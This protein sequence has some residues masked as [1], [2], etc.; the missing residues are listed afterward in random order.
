MIHVH[1]QRLELRPME[2]AD[3]DRVVEILGDEMVKKT[4]MVPDITS[5]EM[6]DKLFQRLKECCT[7]EGR[8]GAGAYFQG[9]L[10][11]FLHDVEISGGTVEMGYAFHPHWH[12]RGFATEAFGA[13]MDA[14]FAQGVEQVLA[15][16]FDSNSASIRVMEKCGM[17]RLDREEDIE[18]RG[19][20]H[21]CVYYGKSQRDASSL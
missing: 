4:Y 6:G 12:G 2:D 9:K 8:Y 14:L 16:A 10:I 3:R 15:G 20:V 18:Y 13:A 7:A 1:T 11:G 19:E 5:R 21:R 17:A